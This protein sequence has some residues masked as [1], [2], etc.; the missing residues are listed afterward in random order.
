[1]SLLTEHCFAESIDD[2]PNIVESP[3]PG[4]GILDCFNTILLPTG[5]DR[6]L[7]VLFV[8]FAVQQRMDVASLD[9]QWLNK[10]CH[11]DGLVSGPPAVA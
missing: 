2:V 8:E 11:L 7:D 6:V 4:R 1:M 9:L 3:Q 10:E 5:R